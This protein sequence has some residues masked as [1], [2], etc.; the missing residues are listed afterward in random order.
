MENAMKNHI[1]SFL[2]ISFLLVLAACSS[3]PTFVNHTPPDLPVAFDEFTNAGCPDGT[4]DQPCGANTPLADFGC[5]HIYA[6]S[7][8]TGGL[9]PP[10]PI[11]I[12]EIDLFA[13]AL[14]PTI[15]SEIDQG[16][17]IYH[18]GGLSRSYLRYVIIQNGEFRL[19]KTVNDFRA[20]YAPIDSP[21]EALSYVLAVTRLSA[22]YGLEYDPAM[23]Y[24]VNEI[25]DTFVTA[26]TDGYRLHLFYY[27][28]FGCGPHW[29]TAMDMHISFDGTIQE[30]S[31]TQIFRD[32]TMDEL[33]VD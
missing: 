29:I 11:A 4:S 16:E 3:N 22:Y 12:C 10:H 20:V 6:P 13:G 17:F 5:N 24:E 9:E 27:Q 19:L 25:E 31:Q 32:P 26:E 14:T 15:E 1:N 23:E 2:R 18:L 8:L 30:I 7:T 21:E 33:C 28:L